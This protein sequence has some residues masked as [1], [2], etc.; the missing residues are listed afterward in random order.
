MGHFSEE[1]CVRRW[2]FHAGRGT[3]AEPTHA[4]PALAPARQNYWLI[5]RVVAGEHHRTGSLK[6]IG[7]SNG[8]QLPRINVPGGK[9]S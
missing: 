5:A 7:I 3:R 6:I 8:P 1:K 9:H 2:F 4:T